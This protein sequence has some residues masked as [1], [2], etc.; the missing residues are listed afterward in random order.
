MCLGISMGLYFGRAS[1]ILY[2]LILY[3]IL[4]EFRWFKSV[5]SWNLFVENNRI[6]LINGARVIE[7]C[8]S[9]ISCVNIKAVCYGG[10]KLDVIGYRLEVK[11]RKKI[12]YFDSTF[13]ESNDDRY[14][15]IEKLQS[16]ILTAAKKASV[17]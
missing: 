7:I 9:E 4:I 10:R 11:T 16:I 3:G 1:Y 6:V 13:I 5:Y 17:Q 14:H 8:I 12:Y 2:A 15:D